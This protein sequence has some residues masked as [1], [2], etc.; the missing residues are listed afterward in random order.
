MPRYPDSDS[1]K[2][3]QRPDVEPVMDALTAAGG[4]PAPEEKE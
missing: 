4:S 3:P 1:A 2:P